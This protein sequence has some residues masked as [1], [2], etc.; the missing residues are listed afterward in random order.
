MRLHSEKEVSSPYLSDTS[1]LALDRR[2][3]HNCFLVLLDS[4]CVAQA[5][6]DVVL[7]P[8]NHVRPRVC[9]LLS[10]SSILERMQAFRGLEH[11]LV[12]L[13]CCIVFL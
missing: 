3:G 2:L 1:V 11:F 12:L 6:Q 5:C 7:N 4:F 10:D 13:N 9:I 8:S